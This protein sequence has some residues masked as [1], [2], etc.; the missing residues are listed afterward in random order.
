MKLCTPAGTCK[1]ADA[2]CG[3][4]KAWEMCGMLANALNHTHKQSQWSTAE[5]SCYTTSCGSLLGHLQHQQGMLEGLPY[6]FFGV[7]KI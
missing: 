7:V 2:V 1:I 5:T 3:E 6:L 4:Y